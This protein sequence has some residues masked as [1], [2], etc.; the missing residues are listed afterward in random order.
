MRHHMTD[1][2]HAFDAY[3]DTIREASLL[4]MMTGPS[5]ARWG[6]EWYPLQRLNLQFGYDGG[7][8]VVHGIARPDAA[9]FM[10]QT[11]K[12]PH[13]VVFDG[14]LLK[15]HDVAV[16]SPGGHFT[17]AADTSC[18]WLSLTVPT[19]LI[20]GLPFINA[21][22]I[23]FQA[24]NVALR[25]SRTSAIQFVKVAM[26][27]RSEA[28]KNANSA[29]ALDS[30]HE[31]ALLQILNNI[32]SDP[33]TDTRPPG[34]YLLSLGEKMAK[35]LEY[36]RTNEFQHISVER[37]ADEMGV[38]TRTLFRAFKT[39][40]RIGPKDYLKYRQLN[41]V[42]RALRSRASNDGV[43]RVMGEFGVTEFGRFA[44][45]YRRLFKELPSDTAARSVSTR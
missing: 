8:R 12:T 34:K 11:V 31:T 37:L 35:V 20:E 5:S 24:R 38:T 9:I 17:F 33:M 28:G 10:V 44:S 7:A 25:L 23:S 45:E 41:N 6:V 2:Q 42:R 1:L 30:A 3:S 4:F 22:G 40:F 43:T 21:H 19:D 13:D 16:L 18:R 36:V 27:V 15:W 26:R 32:L 29:S 14:Q 39:Y